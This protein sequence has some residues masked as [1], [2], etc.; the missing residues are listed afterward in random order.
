MLENPSDFHGTGIV[1]VGDWFTVYCL[2][3]KAGAG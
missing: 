2:L 3:F 1:E